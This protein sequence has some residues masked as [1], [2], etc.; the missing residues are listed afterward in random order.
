MRPGLQ[1][2]RHH[3]HSHRTEKTLALLP[4]TRDLLRHLHDHPSLRS[5]IAAPAD[6]TLLYAGQWVRPVWQELAELRRSNPQVADKVMLPDVLGRLLTPG[7]PELTLLAWA[8]AIDKLGPWR[9]NGFVVWRALSGLFAA[10][11]KGTVSFVVG[12]G[13]SRAD[14]VFAA[15]ELAVLQRNGHVD[16]KTQD[17]LAYYQRCLDRGQSALNFGF[18]AG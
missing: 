8:K 18:I 4:P 12:E 9:D 1:S 15:T 7:A 14:K 13:V 16:E 11:A 17:I 6:K 3:R 2:R 10:N 5:Q